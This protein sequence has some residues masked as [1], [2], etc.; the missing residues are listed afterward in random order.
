MDFAIC[1]KELE[2][3]N[4]LM[5]AETSASLGT[6]LHL[7]LKEFQRLEKENDVLRS[8][9]RYELYFKKS[10]YIYYCIIVSIDNSN[11]R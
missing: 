4:Y 2:C 5:M 1:Q 7:R 3:A 6:V 10:T 9:F 11:M 8:H